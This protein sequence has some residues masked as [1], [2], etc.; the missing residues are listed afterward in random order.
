MCL[1]SLILSSLQ[2]VKSIVRFDFKNYVI[3]PSQHNN[4]GIVELHWAYAYGMKITINNVYAYYPMHRWEVGMVID[5]NRKTIDQRKLV[6][7]IKFP[8]F[9][10]FYRKIYFLNRNSDVLW[11]VDQLRFPLR[12]CSLCH[13][14]PL[15]WFCQYNFQFSVI[16]EGQKSIR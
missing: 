7:S 14:F 10:F 6:N 4:F 9:G 2:I 13:S 15:F 8:A 5:G 3:R 1:L 11:T 16:K 12:T